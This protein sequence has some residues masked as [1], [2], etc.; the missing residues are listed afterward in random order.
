[1][2]KEV[3]MKHLKGG[4]LLRV[5]AFFVIAAVL[6]C[7]A[8]FAAS[9]WQSFVDNEQNNDDAAQVIPPSGE[10]DDN[11][12]DN[13]STGEENPKPET[14]HYLTGV[15]VTPDEANS[16]PISFIYSSDSP[17]YG[18]SSAFLT[19]EIP[20]EN[21]NTRY[22][23]LFQRGVYLGKIGSISPTRDYISDFAEALGTA[24][25]HK[26]NDDSFAYSEKTYGGMDILEN[27]GYSYTEYTDYHYTNSDL[28]NAL[29]KNNGINSMLSE[30]V[31]APFVHSK[32]EIR[33]NE[34]ALSVV[35]P[36]SDS[37][38]TQLVYSASDNA[39]TLYKGASAVKDLLND[40]VC[41]Y[42]NVFVLFADAT[43]R[44]TAEATETI[45]DTRSGGAGFYFTRGTA[46]KITWS[47][48]EAG[49]LVF[50]NERGEILSVNIGTSYIA[51]EKA[52]RKNLISYK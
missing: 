38:T 10:V 29:I 12:N 20:T 23:S 32:T 24:L 15:T 46:F 25:V 39:Y 17:I 5:V 37:N 6:T 18:I 31:K 1:M 34:V 50:Y 4:S 36:Y 47:T 28:V 45:L 22:L 8:T 19:V 43:T 48:D 14:K 21:G 44:E 3:K 41:T 30:S 7:T 35:I 33:G 9:G 11:K 13:E 27:S 16:S 52:S 49:N 51:F 26:G 40:K 42:D 2:R